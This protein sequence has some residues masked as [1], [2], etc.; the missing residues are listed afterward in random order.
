M[1]RDRDEEDE[2]ANRKAELGSNIQM[3]G[4][5]VCISL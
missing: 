5:G 2:E 3:H 4:E 1:T